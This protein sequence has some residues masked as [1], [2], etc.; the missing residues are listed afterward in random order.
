[1][2]IFASLLVA[3][4]AMVVFEPPTF[5]A[6]AS[7]RAAVSPR[8]VSVDAWAKQRGFTVRSHPAQRTVELSKGTTRLVFSVDPRKDRSPMKFNGVNVLLAFPVHVQKG[9]AYVSQLDISETLNPLL[10][11]AKEPAGVRV[12]KIC[13]DAGHGGKDPG[14]R[15]GSRYEKQYTLLLAREVRTYL[16]Q[17]GFEVIMTRNS[18]VFL[19]LGPRAEIARQRRADVFVSLHFN[20]FPASPAVKGV[21]VYCL[22][23]SGAYSSNSGAKGDTRWLA[24]NRNNDQNILLAYNVHGSM[25]RR[26]SVT[27][28]GVKR[29][30]F[31]VLQNA[32]MPSVLVE[33]GFLSNP[34]EG[35]R[36]ADPAYRKQMARAI[37]DGIIAYRKSVER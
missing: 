3:L 25:V 14:F 21:E 9:K 1:M 26:L 20:A 27:D 29:A 24:G 35:K 23:P 36:I 12:R 34:S 16:I 19:D 8:F 4:L 32:T 37:A 7:R 11:P 31:K 15:V 10:S 30:R 22:T 33:G 17:A 6:T 18:D 5:A 2:R 28:R 13:L